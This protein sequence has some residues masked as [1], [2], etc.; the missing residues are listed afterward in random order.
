MATSS[1]SLAASSNLDTGFVSEEE[2]AGLAAASGLQLPQTL[3][4]KREAV[5]ARVDDADCRESD[6]FCLFREL[7][8]LWGSCILHL[9][10]QIPAEEDDG[11]GDDKMM[12]L[13][14][15]LI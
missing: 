12:T 6:R 11:G 9:S 2:E 5:S 4:W 1:A 10:L 8:L 15:L 14:F 7:I 3:K 13:I